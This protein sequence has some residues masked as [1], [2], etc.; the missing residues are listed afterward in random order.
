MTTLPEGVLP[1]LLSMETNIFNTKVYT[2]ILSRCCSWIYAFS[3]LY[4]NMG[5]TFLLKRLLNLQVRHLQRP[6]KD[7]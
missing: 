3:E 1:S 5:G 2:K 7:H 4:V 6:N